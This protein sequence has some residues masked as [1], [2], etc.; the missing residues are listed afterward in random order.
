[1]PFS[2]FSTEPHIDPV[3]PVRY[4]YLKMIPIIFVVV[5]SVGLWRR[6]NSHSKLSNR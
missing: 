4:R 5:F 2:S 3:D 1:M 6:G